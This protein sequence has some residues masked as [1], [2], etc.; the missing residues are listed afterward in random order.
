M[1]RMA[2]CSAPASIATPDHGKV[3][4]VVKRSVIIGRHKTSV[5][6]EDAFWDGLK[7]IALSQRISVSVLIALIDGNRA[8][9]NLSSAIRLY[10]LDHFRSRGLTHLMIG[11]RQPRAAPSPASRS[12]GLP[13]L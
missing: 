11:S 4:A 2:D 3:F 10:V 12:I 7:E 1:N 9:A 6:L 5:S 13:H 8:S